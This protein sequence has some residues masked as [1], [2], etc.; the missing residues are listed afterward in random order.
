ML[1]FP[2]FLSVLMIIAFIT[3]ATRY[4]IPNWLNALVIVLYIVF[5]P[6][7][8]GKVDW[9]SGIYAFL[10]VFLCSYPLFYFRICGGGD[11]KLL[12]TL[13]LWCGLHEVLLEFIVYT[14]LLGGALSLLLISLRPFVAWLRARL[15]HEF[16]VPKL[17][18]YGQ[19][20]PY[21]LAITTAFLMVLWAGAIPGI[22]IRLHSLL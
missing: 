4:I 17:L 6:L 22:P 7:T 14:G 20:I 13:S 18:T 3:D 11:V 19:D 2:I 21:G 15:N 16:P 5:V 10:I 9:L 12:C 8:P 1:F